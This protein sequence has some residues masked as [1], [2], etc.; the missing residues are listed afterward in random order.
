MNKVRHWCNGSVEETGWQNFFIFTAV[1]HYFFV[2]H[3][4][5]TVYL[6]SQIRF[7]GQVLALGNLSTKSAISSSQLTHVTCRGTDFLAQVL[8]PLA[9]ALRLSMYLRIMILFTRF[10][11]FFMNGTFLLRSSNSACWRQMNSSSSSISPSS[12]SSLSHSS[13][14]SWSSGSSSTS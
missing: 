5:K 12:I 4:F 1:I 14:S 7:K 2:L 8:N 10:S 13:F 6:P 11:S 9:R 3:Y